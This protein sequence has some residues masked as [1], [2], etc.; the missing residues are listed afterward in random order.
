MSNEERITMERLRESSEPSILQMPAG[1]T[2]NIFIGSGVV[3]AEWSTNRKCA[4]SS[5]L[6]RRV[7]VP[8]ALK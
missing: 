5:A 4:L 8:L 2:F 3:I 7:E 6:F 1:F